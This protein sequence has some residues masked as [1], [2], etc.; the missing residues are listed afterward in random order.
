MEATDVYPNRPPHPGD[1]SALAPKM[2]S[3]AGRYTGGLWVG[4]Y[5][6]VC[7]YQWLDARG[8]AAVSPPAVRQSAREGLEGH[9]RAA[10][11]RMAQN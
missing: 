4:S 9:R 6:K 10:A 1:L 5:L 3:H 11:F 2:P 8:V 7:T